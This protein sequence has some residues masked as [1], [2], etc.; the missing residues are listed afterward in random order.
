[1][2]VSGKMYHRNSWKKEK[3]WQIYHWLLKMSGEEG[4]TMVN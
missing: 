3:P 1:M 4:P 2:L